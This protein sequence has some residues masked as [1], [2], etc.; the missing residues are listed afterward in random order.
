MSA[1]KLLLIFL[2]VLLVF[3][4]GRIAG[5]GQGLG[6]AIR[7]FKKSSED[8]DDRGDGSSSKK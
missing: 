2:I 3:G 4:A 8:K 7:N 6:Q 5:I 1:G